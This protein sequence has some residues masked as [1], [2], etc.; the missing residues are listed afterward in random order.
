M[1]NARMTA[2]P[3]SGLTLTWVPVRDARGRVRME[4]RWSVMSTARPRSAA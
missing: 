2:A 4:A 1:L 3:R